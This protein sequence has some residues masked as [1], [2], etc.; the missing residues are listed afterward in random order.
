MDVT[1]LALAALAV[2]STCGLLGLAVQG[3]R[4]RRDL[5]DKLVA[6]LAPQHSLPQVTQARCA[7]RKGADDVTHI[8][9][10]TDLRVPVG[11]DKPPPA[12]WSEAYADMNQET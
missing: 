7:P 5:T 10:P 9:L 11:A 12:G 8:P 4:E 1:S 6:A 2:L 3:A